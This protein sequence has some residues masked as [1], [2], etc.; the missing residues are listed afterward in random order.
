MQLL[1]S[2]LQDC[3]NHDIKEFL[4]WFEIDFEMQ[5]IALGLE[6]RNASW[7]PICNSGDKASDDHESRKRKS[8]FPATTF[9]MG[10]GLDFHRE[11]HHV[12]CMRAKIDCRLGN[13]AAALRLDCNGNPGD[14]V[15][16]PSYFF[17]VT[18]HI[19]T[20]IWICDRSHGVL[21]YEE[22]ERKNLRLHCKWR[23]E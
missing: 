8:R 18:G 15:D 19:R 22:K 3:R 13:L 2:L 10:W 5:N 9:E 16:L 14:R 1:N 17:I 7:M 11:T 21:F 20:P 23:C 6:Q 12:V 4:H